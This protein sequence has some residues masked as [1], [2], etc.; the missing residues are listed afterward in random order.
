MNVIIH[1][2][3]PS[4][5]EVGVQPEDVETFPHKTQGGKWRGGPCFLRGNPKRSVLT[6]G[7]D[8]FYVGYLFC[9]KVKGVSNFFFF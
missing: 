3:S 2:G 6:A 4:S 1:S 8:L 5:L 7:I 9:R